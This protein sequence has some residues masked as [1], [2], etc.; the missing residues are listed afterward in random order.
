MCSIGTMATSAGMQ[1]GRSVGSAVG[2]LLP[3]TTPMSTA[4]PSLWCQGPLLRG[5]GC[6]RRTFGKESSYGATAAHLTTRP[7]QNIFRTTGLQP[8]DSPKIAAD[9]SNLP[10][11][12]RRTRAVDPLATSETVVHGGLICPAMTPPIWIQWCMGY[13]GCLGYTT[14]A[15]CAG[16]RGRRPRPRRHRLLHHRHRPPPSRRRGVHGGRHHRRRCHRRR[17]RR[18]C[19]LHRH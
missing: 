16:F 12:L 11:Q 6:M 8:V 9:L 10:H 3:F 4:E 17:Q 2:T 13:Q 1:S 14:W 7:G 18:R 19:I 5:S 15:T